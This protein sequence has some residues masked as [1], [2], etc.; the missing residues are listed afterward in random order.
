[1]SKSHALRAV[2]ALMLSGLAAISLAVA[3]PAKP[4]RSHPRPGVGPGAID[5]A[6]QRDE[7]HRLD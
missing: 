4:R 1:M 5:H 6:R 3:K 7:G 2:S